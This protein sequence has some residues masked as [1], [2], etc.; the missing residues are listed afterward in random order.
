MTAPPKHSFSLDS[1]FERGSMYRLLARCL[2]READEQL[3]RY[4][5]GPEI[6]DVFYA[7]GGRLPE[8]ISAE[9]VELLAVDY[10][11]LFIG[12]SGHLPPVQSVWQSG[13]LR[14]GTVDSMESFLE[15]IAYDRD[16]LP[17]G[18][19]LDHLAVELDLMGVALHAA[20]SAIG[21]TTRSSL[22]E[23]LGAYFA[24]H[25]R[26]PE[27]LL[28]S[29]KDKAETEFYRSVLEMTLAFLGSE[30]GD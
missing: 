5:S 9:S 28:S 24:A 6:R 4:L 17:A 11:A 15:I 20:T 7:A 1:A 23:L 2:M 26:W 14:S 16:S 12:P 27:K 18:I 25:L 29:A 3:L 10:C 30:A 19:E 22:C 8:S 21:D 13:E